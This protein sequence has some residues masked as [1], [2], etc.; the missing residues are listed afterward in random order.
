M[1][2]A[3]KIV[4]TC[5]ILLLFEQEHKLNGEGSTP[6]NKT[7]CLFVVKKKNKKKMLEQSITTV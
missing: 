5:F 1:C 4:F 2:R 6:A 7:I 3:S